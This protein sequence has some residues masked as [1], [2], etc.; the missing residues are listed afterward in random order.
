VFD[1]Y[2]ALGL[3]FSSSDSIS[4]ILIIL[5][6]SLRKLPTHRSF[7]P[8]GP[9]KSELSRNIPAFKYPKDLRRHIQI[10][11]KLELAI[12][13]PAVSYNECFTRSRF[14]FDNN[15]ILYD[16]ST[17]NNSFF[18]VDC[19][20]CTQL[21]KIA[22]RWSGGR[23]D[24][25]NIEDRRGAMRLVVLIIIAAGQGNRTRSNILFFDSSHEDSIRGF[26]LKAGDYV[27]IFVSLPR[28][29]WVCL[30]LWKGGNRNLDYLN[31]RPRKPWR[32]TAVP[33]VGPCHPRTKHSFGSSRIRQTEIG[34]VL[35]A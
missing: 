4:C 31:D 32:K 1:L 19:T 8:R 25:F 10:P 28:Q 24:I 2:L 13:V 3:N 14:G 26:G 16:G 29:F 21:P 34:V 23:E 33:L 9:Y 22:L 30:A 7:I 17:L 6:L 11:T 15:I 27:S 20:G 12:D 18:L 35:N 5:S